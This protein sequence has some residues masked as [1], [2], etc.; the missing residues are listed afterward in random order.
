[1]RVRPDRRIYTP[2]V[3]ETGEG[4]GFSVLTAYELK[5]IEYNRITCHQRVINESSPCPPR[6]R[7]GVTLKEL[8]VV[9]DSLGQKPRDEELMA[10]IAEVDADGSGE[11]EFEEVR[12][13]GRSPPRGTNP[14]LR[15][16]PAAAYVHPWPV[17]SECRA[18][19]LAAARSSVG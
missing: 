6:P 18:L 19:C 8:R 16:A 9:F 13:S 17:L 5:L 7:P 12:S 3:A 10:M 14:A 1:M 15:H 4:V 11:M 2:G